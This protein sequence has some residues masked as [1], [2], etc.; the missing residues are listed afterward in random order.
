[1]SAKNQH[2]IVDSNIFIFIYM[3]NLTS[4]SRDRGCCIGLAAVSSISKDKLYS[5][6]DT[7]RN[8]YVRY[9][10]RFL[11]VEVDYIGLPDSNVIRQSKRS[12]EKR[13]TADK[14]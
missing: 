13:R 10:N 12:S 2:S 3:R 4:A 14:L 5:I 7:Y 8:M 9:L 6:F 1:M 11:C